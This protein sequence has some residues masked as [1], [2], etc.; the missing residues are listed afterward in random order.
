MRLR[1]ERKLKRRTKIK[2]KRPSPSKEARAKARA[3]AE[4]KQSQ[5]KSQSKA[6]SRSAGA[7]T[8][9][10]QEQKQEAAVPVL[11]KIEPAPGGN[12]IISSGFFAPQPM[13]EI[14]KCFLYLQGNE[15]ILSKEGDVSLVLKGINAALQKIFSHHMLEQSF[16]RLVESGL[17]KKFFPD[18]LEED[19]ITALCHIF[20]N[21]DSLSLS[22][23]PSLN[24]IYALFV[25][26]AGERGRSSVAMKNPLIAT[27]IKL[28]RSIWK[29]CR[30]LLTSECS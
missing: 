1:K 7:T 5:S 20:T 11:V 29:I 12:L 14:E 9:K 30:T 6:G 17:M 16:K 24:D 27:A 2:R 22:K 19:Q 28:I 26:G 15:D 8:E 4:P 13:D 23:A 25:R 10:I 21:A 3:K 18:F